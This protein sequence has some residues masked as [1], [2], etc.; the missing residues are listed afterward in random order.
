MNDHGSGLKQLTENDVDD[1]NPF[2]SPDG[3]YLA[4]THEDPDNAD[5]YITSPE[6]PLLLRLT[7]H[8]ADDLGASWR[9]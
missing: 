6:R 4:F 8:P 2:W 5:V 3:R 7:D 9:A 1:V